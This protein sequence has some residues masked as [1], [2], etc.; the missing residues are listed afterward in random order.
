VAR[1]NVELTINNIRRDRP[2]LAVMEPS[3]AIKIAGTMYSLQSGVIDLF[4]GRPPL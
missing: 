3:G 1:K 2:V 4:H